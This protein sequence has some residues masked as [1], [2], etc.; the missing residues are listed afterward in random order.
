MSEK[1]DY[2]ILYEKVLGYQKVLLMENEKLKQENIL[3]KRTVRE[4]LSFIPMNLPEDISLEVPEEKV[5]SWA[6]KS[7]KFKTFDKFL[8]LTII[9]LV[10]AGKFPLHY[11]DVIH[12]FKSRYPNLFNELKNPADTLSRRLRDLRTRGYLISPQK[13]YF[14]LGPRAMEKLKQQTP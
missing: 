4:A 7:E 13:G 1:E 10:K 9:H 2:K 12:A 11:D 3:L 6:E 5:E 14:F 8:F